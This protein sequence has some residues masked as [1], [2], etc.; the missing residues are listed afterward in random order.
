MAKRAAKP[1]ATTSKS[2]SDHPAAKAM[3]KL[4]RKAEASPLGQ[5]GSHGRRKLQRVPILALQGNEHQ[6][7][8]EGSR[9]ASSTCGTTSGGI[10]LIGELSD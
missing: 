8:E 6:D 4:K 2:R 9:S 1:P 7:H 3:P 5:G 10:A